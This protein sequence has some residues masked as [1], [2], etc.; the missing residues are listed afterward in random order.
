MELATYSN[1]KTKLENDLDLIDED[2]ITEAEL[3]GYMNEAID[4]CESIIHNL[5]LEAKYFKTTDTL[6]LVSGTADYSPPA[7]IFA[8]KYVGIYYINGSRKYKI[9]M[10]RNQDHIL[11]DTTGTDYEY[12]LLNLTAGIKMRLYPTPVESGAYI[13]RFYIR[14]VR[15]LTTSTASTN[16]CEI[17]ESINF[18]YQHVKCRVYEKEGNPNLPDAQ[19]KLIQQH[20]LM[21]Q[22]LQEFTQDGNNQIQPDF[23]FYEDMYLDSVGGYTGF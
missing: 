1:I 7:D 9:N 14:N 2:F 16:T 13:T 19:S 10:R 20:D 3:L 18:I 11:D 22:N 12:D 5:G 8:N 23:T 21:V 6:T 17:P 4:D 15:K